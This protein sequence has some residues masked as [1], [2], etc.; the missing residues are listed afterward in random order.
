[1]EVKVDIGVDTH[2]LMKKISRIN[3]E[4][5]DIIASEALSLGA[6][7]LYSS[8]KKKEKEDSDPDKLLK[9]ILSVSMQNNEIASEILSMVF[10]KDKSKLGAFDVE[11]VLKMSE[12][13]AKKA[14]RN[15]EKL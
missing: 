14:I 8:L 12:K 2:A 6:K 15:S 1:M 5:V 10:D 13:I 9:N 3:Q 7:I 4:S 11:T